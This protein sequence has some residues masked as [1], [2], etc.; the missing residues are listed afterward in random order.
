MD[1]ILGVALGLAVRYVVSYVGRCDFKLTGTL[2]GLWEG[3]VLS[4]FLNKTPNSFDP[5]IPYAFRLF[6][7]FYFVDSIPRLVLIIVWTGLGVILADIAPALWVDAGLHRIWRRVRRDLYY[8]S[9]SMPKVALFPR[10]RTVR[11]SPPQVATALS[12]SE[13]TVTQA[14][15]SPLPAPIRPPSKRHVPGSFESDTD[16]I[17]QAGSPEYRRRDFH[18]SGLYDSTST[19]PRRGQSNFPI[20][21]RPISDNVSEATSMIQDVDDG[22]VSSPLSEGPSEVLS[23]VNI[24]VIP[25]EP[26]LEYI[27]TKQKSAEETT[28]Q[29]RPAALPTPTDST[30]PFEH[31]R[32]EDD[33]RRPLTADIRTIPD[34]YDANFPDDWEKVNKGDV[35]AEEQPPPLPRKEQEQK[36]TLTHKA[37]SPPP[38]PVPP[39]TDKNEQLRPQLAQEPRL[40]GTQKSIQK[41][42]SGLDSGKPLDSEPSPNTEH[43][44]PYQDPYGTQAFDSFEARAADDTKAQD[45]YPLTEDVKQNGADEP[46]EKEAEPSE[47]L[48]SPE[49]EQERQQEASEGHEAASTTSEESDY[50]DLG[51][52]SLSCLHQLARL[53]KRIKEVREELDQETKKYNRVSTSGNTKLVDEARVTV[54]AL[55]KKLTRLSNDAEARYLKKNG[56]GAKLKGSVDVSSAKERPD[57][58]DVVTKSLETLLRPSTTDASVSFLVATV[59]Q[60]GNT[61]KQFIR[62]ISAELGLE[63]RTQ[64]SN[65]RLLTIFK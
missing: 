43:P 12:D 3:V 40:K 35:S 25:D 30:H 41:M 47:Q 4:H 33:I 32:H 62:N 5:F 13:T 17:T 37:P 65:F 63:L 16:T 8:I 50:T 53:H 42:D 23:T 27:D 2:V 39:R 55:E 57:L 44:P 19:L 22:N 45:T 14:I 20:Q 36:A 60:G 21:L 24:N 31:M 48:Q 64:P 38:Q 1:H 28:P 54:K 7:D 10:S 6:L 34:D 51:L 58:E 56:Q 52:E 49:Q 26:I 61:Q 15:N 46:P 59:K 9:R 29:R 11:F 18:S